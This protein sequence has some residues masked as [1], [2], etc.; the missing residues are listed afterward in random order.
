M[1]MNG[2][3]I[4]ALS[5]YIVRISVKPTV[6][7]LLVFVIFFAKIKENVVKFYIIVMS[8]FII[9]KRYTMRF[10]DVISAVAPRKIG[11]WLLNLHR[12]FDI[13]VMKKK[14]NKIYRK[15]VLTFCYIFYLIWDENDFLKVWLKIIKFLMI[16]IDF[17]K[18]ILWMS[19]NVWHCKI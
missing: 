4:M 2:L 3:Q 11:W 6:I 12:K 13:P 9:K 19:W 8:S 5:Y 7:L 16:Q 14:T 10:Y 17:F 18:N 15:F 1:R